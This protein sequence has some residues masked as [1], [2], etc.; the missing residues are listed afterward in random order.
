M[1]MI[2]MYMMMIFVLTNIIHASEKPENMIES[3][4]S[5]SEQE[6][7]YHGIVSVENNLG[8]TEP[9]YW[10]QNLLKILIFT[11]AV[12]PDLFKNIRINSSTNHSSASIKTLYEKID[13]AITD[14]AFVDCYIYAPRGITLLINEE[15]DRIYASNE[16]RL[17]IE[18]E[19]RSE[20]H[21]QDLYNLD[22]ARQSARCSDKSDSEQSVDASDKVLF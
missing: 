13:D 4:F 22:L 21:L 2:Y 11:R 10:D 8:L 14:R 7:S 19:K 12:R 5:R 9:I 6:F 17:R 3:L 1:K 20:K 15:Q 16:E 18:S